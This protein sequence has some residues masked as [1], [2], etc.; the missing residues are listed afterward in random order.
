MPPLTW[1]TAQTKGC[2]QQQNDCIM[3]HEEKPEILC[4]IHRRVVQNICYLNNVNNRSDLRIFIFAYHLHSFDR[5]IKCSADIPSAFFCLLCL[6]NP[7]LH[8]ILLLLFP[9]CKASLLLWSWFDLIVNMK[10]KGYAIAT[11]LNVLLY[12]LSCCKWL[13]WSHHTLFMSRG[14]E[15]EF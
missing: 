13:S 10:K 1:H 7:F 12:L 15:S 5:D 6:V 2:I 3:M 11:L 8:F 14:F 9:H 4:S